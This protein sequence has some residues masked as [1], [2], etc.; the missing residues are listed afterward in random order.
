MADYELSRHEE[1]LLLQ[2]CRTL[3][4]LEALQSIVESE[5]LMRPD[6]FGES[7]P[8]PAAVEARQLRMLFA[9]LVVALRVPIGDAE[10]HDPKT[11]PVARR[12]Q[13]RGLR[14]F[15]SIAGGAS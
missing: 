3:D 1:S 4:D 6:R 9:R 12:T 7:K 2:A 5:G 11:S 15:T 13:R 10:V 8:H 14:G